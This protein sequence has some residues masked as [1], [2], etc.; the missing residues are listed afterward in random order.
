MHTFFVEIFI[1]FVINVVFVI[2]NFIG[3]LVLF[4]LVKEHEKRDV[5]ENDFKM[6]FSVDCVK[7]SKFEMIC[8]TSN[9]VREA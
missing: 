2:E 6:E 9:D 3:A 1:F 5:S 8:T 7:S 4:Q